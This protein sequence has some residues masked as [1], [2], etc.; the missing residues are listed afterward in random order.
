MWEMSSLL[1]PHVCV[2]IWEAK[3]HEGFPPLLLPSSSAP[4]RG[5]QRQ[6]DPSADRLRD[7]SEEEEEVKSAGCNAAEQP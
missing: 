7:L 1:S 5:R 4:R 3:S 6:D 2:S